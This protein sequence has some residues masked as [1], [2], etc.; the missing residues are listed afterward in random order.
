[1]NSTIEQLQKPTQSLNDEIKRTNSDL[2]T[3]IDGACA[4][5]VDLKELI[6]TPNTEMFSNYEKASKDRKQ[7]WDTIHYWTSS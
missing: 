4:K 3:Q 1:M 7:L 5:V 6:T 2:Q